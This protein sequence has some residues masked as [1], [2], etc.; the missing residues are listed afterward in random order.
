MGEPKL[1]AQ[2]LLIESNIDLFNEVNHLL[3]TLKTIEFPHEQRAYYET[4]YELCEWLR[5]DI[6]ENLERAKKDNAVV[7][8]REI[9]SDTQTLSNKLSFQS[10]Y[11][12]PPL[13]RYKPEDKLSLRLLTWLHTEHQAVA[14]VP[15]ALINE[16][17]QAWTPEVDRTYQMDGNVPSSARRRIVVVV[18]GIPVS[19][20]YGLRFQ[21]LFFHEFGH[22]LF[23]HHRNEMR[24]AISTLQSAID[25]QQ[26]ARVSRSDKSA[27]RADSRR[28]AIVSTWY[29]WCEEFFC[30]AVGLHIG[31]ASLSL[32]T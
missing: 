16:S 4:V 6:Q 1:L 3:V 8:L 30:D 26:V 5:W 28:G 12:I 31:G 19:A 22:L 7:R 20:Q 13:L 17:F 24:T 27:Q 29:Q 2:Q 25:N 32:C 21:P 11:Y 10:R 23:A 15:A 18:Y 14:D 9:F